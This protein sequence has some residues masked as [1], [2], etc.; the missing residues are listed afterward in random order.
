MKLTKYV[1]ERI[2][3]AVEGSNL[4]LCRIAASCEITYQTLRNWLR[5]GEDYKQQLENG[6]IKKSDLTANEKR[7][8]DLFLRVEVAR[9][10][11]EKGYLERIQ[12]IAEKN[13]DARAY[14]WL[15]KIRNKIYRDADV[16]DGDAASSTPEV[17][18][19]VNL[20][21]KGGENGQLL[22]EF[23]QGIPTNVEESNA[24]II[25]ITSDGDH[26]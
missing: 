21:E 6:R 2:V 11:V 13:N 15:L 17:I 1:E 23:M 7:K 19:V 26:S 4:P 3:S 9:T 20:S 14:Q 12:E 24:E 10:N 25:E 5:D 16:E 8:L 22:R 18:V